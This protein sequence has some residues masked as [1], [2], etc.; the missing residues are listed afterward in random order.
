MFALLRLG[1]GVVLAVLAF[2]SLAP[3]ACP[4]S[5]EVTAAFPAGDGLAVEVGATNPGFLGSLT[6]NGKRLVQGL[7]LDDATR[8]Q[9]R[10]ELISTNLHPLASVATWHGA[11]HLPYAD[12][13]VNLLILDRDALAGKVPSEAECRRVVAPG[14]V[15][16]ARTGG[17]WTQTLVARPPGFADW[18]HFDGGSDGNAVS[19]DAEATA[20]HGLQWIDNVR[21]PRWQKTGP[22]G[23]DQG[24]IRILGRYAI[25]DVFIRPM[26][27]DPKFEPRV[28][29][30]CRDVNNGLLIWQKPR[31]D[32]VASK[33]WAL[34]AG[35]GMC[36][37]WMKEDGP[38]TAFDLT[39]G[40][41]VRTYP[42]SEIKPYMQADRKNKT[43]LSPQKGIQGDNHWVRVAGKTVL[44]N[45]N[46][47][48]QAWT[49]EGK[50][51]WT[52]EK[53]GERLEL[54]A[55]D[56]QRK[57]VYGLMIQDNPVNE[58]GRGPMMWQRWPSSDCVKSII[59]LDLATGEKK[60]ENTELAS[61]DS[62]YQV[63]DTKAP[64]YTAFGQ[65]MAAGDYVVA[66]NDSA[67]SGGSITLAASLDSATGKTVQFNPRTFD[68]VGKR[69][70]H[71]T[72]VGLNS[73]VFRDGMVYMMNSASMMSFDPK[74]GEAKEVF[75][76]G[77]N[78]R[79]A[80]AIATKDKFLL[81][82]T[83]FLGKDLGGE[84]YSLAR[85]GC[86]QSPVPGAGLILFGPHLCHCVTH[87]DGYFATTSRPAP[88]PLPEGQRLIKGTD[89]P[90]GLPAAGATAIAQGLITESWPWF[91]IS[92]PVKPETVEK[93]GWS[94]YVVP[95]A[96]RIEAGN[97]GNKWAYSADARIGLDFAVA[98]ERVV[99]GTHDGWVHGL[100]LK[101][102]ALK[103]RYLVAPAHRLIIANG[104]LTSAWPVFGV[105]DLGNGQVVA[106]AGTHVELDGGVRVVALRAEDGSLVWAKTIS[107]TTSKIP[108][109]GKGSQI[110]EHSL[111]NAAPSVAGGKVVIDGGAHLGRLEFDP[112][113]P[114]ASICKRLSEKPSGKKP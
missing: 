91:T 13:L 54:P 46:G 98:G 57:V 81:A 100:D 35:E 75:N 28:F 50:L 26:D 41:E 4:S 18:T 86:A 38:L 33:R 29:L 52:F 40:K 95:Q 7:T 17:A 93:A 112:A 76:M 113:E 30:E 99:I 109:G 8:D 74:S 83:A 32:S 45:G 27:K 1:V 103:W 58:W 15:I 106:S 39:T 55:V 69:G 59:A 56:E 71:I 9:V 61:R 108:P 88:P 62:G 66:T 114:E 67:I 2:A 107:K 70:F 34:A 10:A 5:A 94:F 25:I 21:E 60:W 63:W 31:P 22:H 96:Q 36:F 23:G 49:L 14:G 84:M 11:P 80:K 79:C 87:F 20:I 90:A 48:L 3:A 73:S 102:G 42:G 64:I 65:L 110:V 51:L 85:S 44:A 105:A 89:K 82:Q 68:Q 72:A 111:I 37:T 24:N 19:A 97:G 12:R 104:M 43:K 6:N 77:W 16:L 92:E 53:T 78:G 101:T 47:P